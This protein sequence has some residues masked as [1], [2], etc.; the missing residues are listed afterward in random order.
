MVAKTLDFWL[1][2]NLKIPTS[3]PFALP[4]YPQKVEF[5]IAF[6]RNILEYLP[7]KTIGISIILYLIPQCFSWLAWIFKLVFDAFFVNGKTIKKSFDTDLIM[8]KPDARS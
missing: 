6:P 5:C 2:E 7:N 8:K 1:S 4:I 3:E